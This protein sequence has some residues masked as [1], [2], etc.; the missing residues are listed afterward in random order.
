M[1]LPLSRVQRGPLIGWYV[2][3]SEAERQEQW[4]L[5]S[6]TMTNGRKRSHLTSDRTRGLQGCQYPW[7]TRKG[8]NF[9]ISRLI[10]CLW[11][12]VWPQEGL[13]WK[14][15]KLNFS[16]PGLGWEL[17]LW[18]NLINDNNNV[19]GVISYTWKLM[20]RFTRYLVKVIIHITIGRFQ[21]SGI[22]RCT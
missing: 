11:I 18:V 6:L 12:P 20:N 19:H 7:Q 15:L 22:Y 8:G 2:A 14:W 4:L 13:H 5:P 9:L 17:R 21:T 10:R 16:P 3:V 1:C